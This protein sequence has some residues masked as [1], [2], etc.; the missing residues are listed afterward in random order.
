MPSGNGDAESF[1]NEAIESSTTDQQYFGVDEVRAES[2]SAP[3]E[4]PPKFT[5]ARAHL[6]DMAKGLDKNCNETVAVED[7]IVRSIEQIFK[8]ADLLA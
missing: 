2:Y 5:T 4:S 7:S 1:K 6:K 3:V 8:A